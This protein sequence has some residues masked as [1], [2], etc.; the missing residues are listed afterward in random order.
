MRVRR[1]VWRGLC[2]ASGLALLWA[3]PATASPARSGWSAE[4]AP[5]PQGAKTSRLSGV[6]C[7]T[8]SACTAVGAIG[9]GPLAE[10]WDGSSWRV[11]ATPKLSDRD[12]LSAV[13]CPSARI[14]LAVGVTFSQPGGQPLTER[15]N[16]RRWSIQVLPAPEVGVLSAV[17]CVA[18]NACVAVGYDYPHST[19]RALIERW[20][21][22]GWTRQTVPD[23]RNASLAGV[24]CTSARACTAVGTAVEQR[25]QVALVERWNGRQWTVQP[26]PR[27]K[28]DDVSLTS[29]SCSSASSCIAVGQKQSPPPCEST[30]CGEYITTTTVV[31]HW[32][33]RRWAIQR[34]HNPSAYSAFSGVSC[35][36]ARACT[37]VGVAVPLDQSSGPLAERWTGQTWVVQHVP[38]SRGHAVTLDGVI[39]LFRRS[40]LAVGGSSGYGPDGQATRALAERW[41]R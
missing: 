3:L 24:S 13:A 17:S 37:A 5:N 38:R 33:G 6:S 2:W 8:A 22:H 32:N 29:V 10:R 12:G 41:N 36:S 40:C 11:Q 4:S 19:Q 39:C 28:P 31:E 21:A 18:A 1:R 26:T 15:W 16:G 34:S 25:A 9:R 30:G 20:G 14:C 23:L 7:A 27:I 35:T